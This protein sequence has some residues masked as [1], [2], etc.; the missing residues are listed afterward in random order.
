MP[1][2]R[3]L[4]EFDADAGTVKLLDGYSTPFRLEFLI[5]DSHRL[6]NKSN[7]DIVLIPQPSDDPNDPLNWPYWKKT[8]AFIPISI[9][10]TVAGWVIGGPAAAIPLLMEEF[11]MDLKNT[12]DAIINWPVLLL[13]LGVHHLFLSTAY[14]L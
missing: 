2:F 12:V 7:S 3:S 9:L 5:L 13:G 8:A 14:S 11:N 10:A 6:K 4:N 1:T